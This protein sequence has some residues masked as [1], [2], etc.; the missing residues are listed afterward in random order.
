MN[1]NDWKVKRDSTVMAQVLTF[2][3]GLDQTNILSKALDGTV[4]IQTIGSANPYAEIEILC[5][6]AQMRLVNSAEA[7]GAVINAEYREVRYFG[8]IEE[9]P[10]WNAVMPGEWYK[11]SIKLLIQDEVAV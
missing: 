1:I 7:D 11:T 4:Y 10:T 8:Y 2:V 6:A 3:P 5:N 9:P